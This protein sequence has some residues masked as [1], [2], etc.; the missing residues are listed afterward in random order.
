[1]VL[2]IELGLV[3]ARQ[4]LYYLSH[5]TRPFCVVYFWD[6]V[7]TVILL[8][9]LHSWGDRHTVPSHWLR[10]GGL[11]N[12]LPGLASRSPLPKKL[13][14]QAWATVPGPSL[15]VFIQGM[16]ACHHLILTFHVMPLCCNKP[17]FLLQIFTCC[18][19]FTWSVG[20]SLPLTLYLLRKYLCSL[21]C[22]SRTMKA[23]LPS[24]L[25][26]ALTLCCSLFSCISSVSYIIITWVHFTPTN[27]S[28]IPFAFTKKLML[29]WEWGIWKVCPPVPLVVIWQSF[30]A[31]AVVWSGYRGSKVQLISLL[32]RAWFLLF[33]RP[34]PKCYYYSLP[35]TLLATSSNH[36]TS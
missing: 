15:M 16:E 27:L 8:I 32:P 26:M 34:S 29:S 35:F 25:C 10:W 23:S 2:G 30:R 28:I 36:S 31:C 14:L 13:G 20:S 11:M 24:L 33:D 19:L 18:L 9:F 12:F 5:S 7:W 17:V 3:L 1:V 21:H 4:V 6:R 22:W